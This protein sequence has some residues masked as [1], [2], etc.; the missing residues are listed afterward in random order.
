MAHSWLKN[1]TVEPSSF[2]KKLHEKTC[3]K[4]I[5]SPTSDNHRAS[6]LASLSAQQG[7]LASTPGPGELGELTAFHLVWCIT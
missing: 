6:E 3:Q 4:S 5:H 2:A 1:H 7:S